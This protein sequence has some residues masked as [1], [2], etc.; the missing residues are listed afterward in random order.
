M[1]Q[2]R[3][4]GLVIAA[5]TIGAIAVVVSGDSHNLESPASPDTGG[6]GVGDTYKECGSTT[7]KD[8]H[9]Y[10]LEQADGYCDEK[11]CFDEFCKK[12]EDECNDYEWDKCAPVYKQ[13]RLK[14]HAID[15][16]EKNADTWKDCCATVCIKSYTS[17]LDLS[18]EKKYDDY[19]TGDNCDYDCSQLL[20]KCY[21]SCN[22]CYV[23]TCECVKY[24]CAPPPTY[25]PTTYEP[26]TYEPTTYAPAPEPY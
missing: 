1:W 7:C 22:D 12:L 23:P 13:R 24:K 26:T 17:C 6:G 3:K 15:D 19:C 14:G 18:S 21:S 4:G 25:A 10:C 20:H 11:G 5:I 8:V 16:E 9:A 2:L